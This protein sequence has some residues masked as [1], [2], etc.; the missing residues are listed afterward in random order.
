MHV[1]YVCTKLNK[2]VYALR[3]LQRV[4]GKEA[5]LVAYYG[6]VESVLR[7]GLLLWGNSTD[8]NNTFVSQKKC[9]RALCNLG[10]LE[11]CRPL[12]KNYNILTLVGLYVLEICVHVKKF[13]NEFNSAYDNSII[14]KRDPTRL[15]MPACRTSLFQR[16]CYVMCIR[17]FIKVLKYIRELPVLR[18]KKELKK[19]LTHHTFYTIK[20]LFD[21]KSILYNNNNNNNKHLFQITWIHFC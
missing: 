21:N 18:M 2:F 16:N 4:A 3:K 11:S 9:I 17:V 8:I 7:N 15:L 13:S 12:F 19:W 20:E 5:A 6:Y 1:K 14:G 10:P